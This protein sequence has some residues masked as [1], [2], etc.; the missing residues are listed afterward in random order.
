MTD[1]PE[2][3]PVEGRTEEAPSYSGALEQLQ[4]ILAELESDNVDVD[5]LAARVEQANALIHLCQERLVAAELQ[6]ERVVE[7]LDAN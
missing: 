2:S 6:V 3:Q 7:T 5:H 1:D 4:Q